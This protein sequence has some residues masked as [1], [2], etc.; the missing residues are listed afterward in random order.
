MN[1]RKPSDYIERFLRIRTKDNRIIPFV[2]NAPQRKLLGVIERQQAAGKPVRVIILKARQMGFS[3]LAEALLFHRTATSFNTDSLIVAHRE[4]STNNLFQMSKLYYDELPTP[5]KPLLKTS[6]AYELRFEN[7]TKDPAEKKREP[8]L[9]SKIRCVTAG[10]RGIGRSYT[11][12]NVHISE[13]AFWEGDKKATLAGLLQAVPHHPDTMV[14]IESTANGYDDFK[15]LWD[16]AARGE[17][18][19]EPVFFGWH[20]MGEYRMDAVPGTEWTADELALKAT[21]SLDDEQLQWRRWCIKNNCGGDERMFRQEYPASADEAFLT[22]G[23]GVFDNE[24]ISRLRQSAP[25]PIKKGWFEYDYDGLKITNIRWAENKTG[26][27]H[28][29]EDPKTG[30]PYVLGGDT[31]GEG[32]DYFT[33]HV[34]D[35]TTGKQVCKLR[36]QYGEAEYARQMY[37]LGMHYNTAL[38][39]IEANYSTYPTM[40]LERLR[41]PKQYVRQ[42]EDD[43][44]H[45][46]K[47][48]FGFMTTRITRPIIIAE[49][50]K[51]MQETPGL[52]VDRDTLGEMLSFVYNE[53]RRPEAMQ[54]E[55]DDLVMALAIAHYIRSQQSVYVTPPP[56]ERVKWSKT[57][58]ED[59][60]RASR[61]ERKMLIKEW[62]VPE[63]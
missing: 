13:Y 38:I 50:V 63:R 51:I 39:G 30:Y 59:Y 15:E 7:P 37:C 16:T 40:E 12:N 23:T 53:H 36:H 3:T 48:S 57:M 33:G 22:T 31:A 9:R 27:V 2:L 14:I 10:G 62:G 19:F 18:D 20:E 26:F 49:L 5:I 55:H 34:L 1:I 8:G 11:C 61:E 44:T 60:N 24:R 25:A 32:S 28:I 52:V 56:A 47:H 41:Y 6:N 58:L 43:F 42:T 29:Y 17:S 21:Y 35:N 4:D 54:G 46:V 45:K